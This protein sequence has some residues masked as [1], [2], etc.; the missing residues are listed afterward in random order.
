MDHIGHGALLV[1]FPAHEGTVID[2]ERSAVYA[3]EDQ[4]SSILDRGG[5]V[6]FFG[7]T[8]QIAPQLRFADLASVARYVDVALARIQFTGAPVT[9]RHRKGGTRAHYSDGVIAL[10]MHRLWSGRE[11]VVLH[12]LAHHLN[13][14][15]EPAHGSTYR[16]HMISLAEAVQSPESALIL[17][18]AYGEAGLL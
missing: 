12:E 13:A 11:A 7:S 18:T 10:P 3:A 14:G 2:R 17:S 15:Q 5:R 16:M 9:V 8:L 1:E 6:D 4:W